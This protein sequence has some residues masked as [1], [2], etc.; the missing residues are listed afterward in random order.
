MRT[1]KI[2]LRLLIV[3]ESYDASVSDAALFLINSGTPL[4]LLQFTYFEV[5]DSKLFEVRTVLG[6]IPDQ[7]GAPADGDD[8]TPEEGRVNWVLASVAE[9]LPDIARRH[10]WTLK[11]VINK[12]SLP[13][14]STRW[15]TTLDRCQLVLGVASR[16]KLS[17]R[18]KFRHDDLPGLREL[19]EQRRDDWRE[20]FPAE[21]T[22]PPYR[23]VYTY[24]AYEVPMPK[25]GNA[26]ALAEVVERTERMTEA[27]MPLLDEYFAHHETGGT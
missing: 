16:D 15:P 26:G 17:L 22:S 27:M 19:M 13:M 23:T 4:A 1:E 20:Q 21:F 5:G 2:D 12:Q 8:V 3:A 6:E 18:L 7:R 10:E 24:L 25:M 11:H 9:R 14:V